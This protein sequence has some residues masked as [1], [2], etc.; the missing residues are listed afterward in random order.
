[1]SS[2]ATLA[3]IIPPSIPMILYAV[4][5]GDL[6]GPALRRRHRARASSAASGM[7]GVAYWFARRYNLP[8]RGSRSRWA[9]V[10]QDVQGSAVGVPAADH[11]PRRHLRRRRHRDR[12]RGARGAWRRCS[13]ASSIYREL[14]VQAAA[15]G[16]RRRR[17][18]DG[19]RDAAGRDQRAA[20]HLPDRGAGAAAARAGRSLDFTLEQV[21]GAGAAERAVPDPRHVPALGRGDH[22][23]RAG[24]DAAGHARSASTRCISG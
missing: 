23:G 20:R 12:G 7:M 13:S 24:R 9:R 22:P 16:D 21:G 3:V 17:R 6:G 15:Q 1:M 19:G 8:R 5:A 18:A 14:D 11:H 10:R 4:M 2:A